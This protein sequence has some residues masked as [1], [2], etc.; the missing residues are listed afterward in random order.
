MK[1]AYR[2]WL[3]NDGKAFGKG[4]NELLKRVAESRSLRQAASQ[5]GMSYSKAWSLINGIEQRLGFPLLERVVGGRAGG[6]SRLTPRA[7]ELLVRYER[8]ER[9]VQQAMAEI[10]QDRF[11]AWWGVESEESGQDPGGPEPWSGKG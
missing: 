11:G 7:E 10:Y 2:V 1:I 3:E 6:G 8:L 5:M 4:P 9:D